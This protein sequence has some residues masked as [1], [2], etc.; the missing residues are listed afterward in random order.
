LFDRKYLKLTKAQYKPSK[1]QINELNEYGQRC[2]AS[3]LKTLKDFSPDL[4]LIQLDRMELA[5]F[6]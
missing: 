6:E 4:V 2:I 5:E 1:V 3:T